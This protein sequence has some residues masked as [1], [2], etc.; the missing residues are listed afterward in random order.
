MVKTEPSILDCPPE[1]IAEYPTSELIPQNESDGQQIVGECRRPVKLSVEKLSF[2]A[3][4]GVRC[5]ATTGF[6]YPRGGPGCYPEIDSISGRPTYNKDICPWLIATKV[7]E[8]TL[9]ILA[10]PNKTGEKRE[11]IMGVPAGNCFNAFTIT[12]SAD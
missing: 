1:D 12:Q 3:Y 7:D 8:R 4:G 6:M 10:S 9:H 2:S 11:L 5:V